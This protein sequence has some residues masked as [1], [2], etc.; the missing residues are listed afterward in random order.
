MF[1]PAILHGRLALDE[2]RSCRAADEVR[3]RSSHPKVLIAAEAGFFPVV[4][5]PATSASRTLRDCAA[6]GLAPE[7]LQQAAHQAL[8]RGLVT[9]DD[10]TDV[11]IALAPFGGLAT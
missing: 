7:S 8:R 10:L 5:V 11:E 3:R 1:Q 2:L 4:S 6:S 9:R